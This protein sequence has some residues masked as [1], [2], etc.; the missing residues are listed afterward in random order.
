VRVAGGLLSHFFLLDDDRRKFFDLR[1]T[2]E[3]LRVD[4]GT[5]CKHFRSGQSCEILC[6][7]DMTKCGKYAY[8]AVPASCSN[9]G[10]KLRLVGPR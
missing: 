4:G 9:E 6:D 8:V 5:S 2:L 3:G 7:T 10:V 1:Q